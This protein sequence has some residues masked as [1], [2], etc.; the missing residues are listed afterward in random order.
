MT[1]SLKS[2]KVNVNGVITI[3]VSICS[4]RIVSI[5]IARLLY[6]SIIYHGPLEL[7]LGLENLRLIS[8]SSS[9]PT[10]I[11]SPS[12]IANLALCLSNASLYIDLYM[13]WLWNAIRTFLHNYLA[14]ARFSSQLFCSDSWRFRKE[15]LRTRLSEKFLGSIRYITDSLHCSYKLSVR[16]T[17]VYF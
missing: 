12:D 6:S 10:S 9:V 7:V 15:S 2:S 1:S 8:T 5:R 14:R 3:C 13:A 17:V 4:C 11:E 16:P